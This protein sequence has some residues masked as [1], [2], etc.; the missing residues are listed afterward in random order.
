MGKGCKIIHR[1]CDPSMSGS[2]PTI[3][4]MIGTV[5]GGISKYDIAS[6]PKQVDI[7]DDYWDKYRHDFDTMT[8]KQRVELILNSGTIQS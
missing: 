7:F 1:D 4:L 2:I 3:L 6:G 5:E 8:Q